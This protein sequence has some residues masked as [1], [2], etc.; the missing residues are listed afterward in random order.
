MALYRKQKTW[1]HIKFQ[2]YTGNTFFISTRV[3]NRMITELW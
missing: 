1:R 3:L 2:N